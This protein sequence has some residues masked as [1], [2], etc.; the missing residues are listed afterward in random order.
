MDNSI[1]DDHNQ[2]QRIKPDRAIFVPKMPTEDL[3]AANAGKTQCARGHCLTPENTKV[4]RPPSA[5]GVHRYCRTFNREAN[6]AWYARR[7][8]AA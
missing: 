7:R 5:A 3:T 8:A 4:S 2:G 1:L 6:R